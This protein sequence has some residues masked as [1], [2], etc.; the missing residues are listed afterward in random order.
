MC[1]YQDEEDSESRPPA[2]DAPPRCRNA[3][4][5]PAKRHGSLFIYTLS[6]ACYL[7]RKVEVAMSK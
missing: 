1:I 6:G 7:F 5:P 2:G 4:Y 3:D